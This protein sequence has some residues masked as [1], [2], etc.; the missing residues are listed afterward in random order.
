[1]QLVSGVNLLYRGDYGLSDY[2]P[3]VIQESYTNIDA[4]LRLRSD[5]GWSVAL[6]GKNL[7]DEYIKTFSQDGPST[8]GGTGTADGYAGDRYA[9]IKP[10]RTMQLE[11][12]YE[13]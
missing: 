3:S 10:G 12:R 13:M 8:G 1:M 5:S 7:S 2:M 9:Y 11:L 6:I 4:V